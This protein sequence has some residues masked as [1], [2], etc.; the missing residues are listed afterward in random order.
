MT[1]TEPPTHETA[2]PAIALDDFGPASVPTPWRHRSLLT[3]G[4]LSRDDVLLL[5]D[6]AESFFEVSRRSVRKVPALRGKT[7]LNLFFEASTRTRTSFELAGKRLSMDVVNLSASSSSTTKGETLLDTIKNAR[8]DAP[9]RSSSAT[10]RAAPREYVARASVRGDQRRRRHARAPHAG[11]ARRVHDPPHEGHGFEGLRS[12]SAA[13]S[14][15]RGSRVRTRSCSALGARSALRP[16][17]TLIPAARTRRDARRRGLRP[18]RAGARGRGRRHDAA[19]P[20]RAALAG[21]FLP[22]TREYSRTFG[23]EARAARAREARRDRDAPRADQPRRR[24]LARGRR[25]PA[26][27]DPRSGRGRRRRAHGGALRHG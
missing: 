11:A 21:V 10:Q 8:G 12:R 14:R 6:A 25:R 17:H 3:A 27:R 20:A 16:P 15:T 5:L 7:L 13:T 2:L 4:E 9:T 1:G 24:D 22:S 18:A 26:E 23:L 19:R